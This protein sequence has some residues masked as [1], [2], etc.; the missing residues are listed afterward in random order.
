MLPSPF[1]PTTCGKACD[2]DALVDT[3][4]AG[5]VEDDIEEPTM[6]TMLLVETGR[7]MT[8]SKLML[9][10]VLLLL[11][12]LT[13]A[14]FFANLLLQ[15]LRRCRLDGVW[16]LEQARVQWDCGEQGHQVVVAHLVM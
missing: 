9:L 13:K 2:Q 1:S 6:I 14:I 5:D 8:I 16:S 15:C 4:D 7:M 3:D 10:M 12:I 11:V